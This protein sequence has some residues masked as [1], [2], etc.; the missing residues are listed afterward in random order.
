MEPNFYEGQFI[1][2][3]KLAYK[4][5]APQ[6]GDIVVFHNPNNPDEDYIKR[7]IGLPGDTLEIFNQSVLINGEPLDE[8]YEQNVLRPDTYFGPVVIEP[9]HLFVMG[10]NRPN[11]KDSR[12]FGQLSSDLVVGRAWVRVWP[13]TQFGRVGHFGLEANAAA[14]ANP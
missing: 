8:P 3:N 7:V 10:D 2:V 13:P 12:S 6:R 4:L 9:D 5:G 1:L 14:Q 11:S